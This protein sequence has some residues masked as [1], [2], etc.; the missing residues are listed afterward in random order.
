MA[1]S[2]GSSVSIGPGSGIVSVVDCDPG[3]GAGGVPG[4]G[5][6][7]GSG[8]ITGTGVSLISGTGRLGISPCKDPGVRQFSGFA[9][10]R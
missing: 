9:P 3:K 7:V 6:V 1:E 5:T 10:L 2:M 4:A 8:D